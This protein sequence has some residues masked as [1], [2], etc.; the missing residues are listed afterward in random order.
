LLHSLRGFVI[1]D[2]S[3]F[4]EIGMD[5]LGRNIATVFIGGID[6]VGRDMGAIAKAVFVFYN[7]DLEPLAFIEIV[8]TGVFDDVYAASLVH[9][10]FHAKLYRLIFLA[11]DDGPNVGLVQRDTMRSFT[12]TLGFFNIYS[13][14]W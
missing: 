1:L 2:G 10:Y 12:L 7:T 11:P 14:C 4:V 3:L 8:E 13:C 9:V 5:A 6:P